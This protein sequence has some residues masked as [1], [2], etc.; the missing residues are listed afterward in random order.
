ML[1]CISAA[2]PGWAW[3]VPKG[4]REPRHASAASGW[5]VQGL[6]QPDEDG[7]GAG[8]GG[9]CSRQEETRGGAQ[10]AMAHVER[11]LGR[12]ESEKVESDE[13]LLET[14]SETTVFGVVQGGDAE[15]ARADGPRSSVHVFGWAEEREGTNFKEVDPEEA[16]RNVFYL[17]FLAPNTPLATLIAQ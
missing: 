5:Q 14:S 7:C 9:R 16:P 10:E 2:V 13:I 15:A 17:L 1:S 3:A 11:D 6:D 8:G 4:P 12:I